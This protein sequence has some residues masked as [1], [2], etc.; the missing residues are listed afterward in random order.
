MANDFESPDQS[1]RSVSEKR[2]TDLWIFFFFWNSYKTSRTSSSATLSIQLDSVTDRS[3]PAAAFKQDIMFTA[4]AAIALLFL[5]S[6]SHSVPPPPGALED[7]V[8]P[9]DQLDSRH[10][11]GRW[12]LVAASMEEKSADYVKERD[13]VAIYFHNSSY[14]QVN[15]VGGACQYQPHNISLE[16]HSFRSQ[17]RAFNFNGTFYQTSCQDCVLVGLDMEYSASNL[18]DFY[19]LSRGREVDQSVMEEFKAQMARL[20][21]PATFMMDPTKELCAEQ[22]ASKLDAQ[23]E[24][25]AGGQKA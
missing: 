4:A 13:S 25:E 8:R 17:E 5:V 16:G 6:A 1:D 7:T 24:Q 19:L 11:E 14:T 15:R 9:L 10:L 22:P 20:K 23:N 2:D 3:V 12:A 18:T 21:M